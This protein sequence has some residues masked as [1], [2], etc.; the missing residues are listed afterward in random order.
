MNTNQSSI[1]DKIRELCET[2]VSQPDFNEIRKRIAAFQTDKGVV[3]HVQR[4]NGKGAELQQK[5][6]EGIELTKEE[7]EAFQT[8]RDLLL[9]NP[10]AIGYFQAQEEIHT[11]RKTVAQYVTKTFELGR[12]PLESEVVDASCGHDCGCHE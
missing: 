5:Q 3:E 11:V 9:K 4:L 10:I 2:I 12:M 1:Q 6:Q 8:D 7:V